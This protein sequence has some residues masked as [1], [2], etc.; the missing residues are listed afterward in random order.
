[1][2]LTADNKESTPHNI[3]PSPDV[4]AVIVCAGRGERT[5]L[6]YNKILYHIGRKTVIETTLDRFVSSGIKRCVLVVSERDEKTITELAHGYDGVSV[7]IG[8]ATRAKSVYN[9]LK[10]VKDCD[11]VVIHDGARPFVRPEIID[12]AVESAIKFGSGIAAVPTTDTIK[13]A[14]NGEVIRSLSRAN[15]YNAQTPQ[16]FRYNEIVS[17]YETA[18][19]VFT[20]DA[21]V[22]ASAGYTPRLVEGAYDNIKIT[23]ENDLVKSIPSGT[24][25]GIGFDVH[26]LVIGR[27]LILGGVDIPYDK[28]L[29]GHS[30]A[31]VLTHAIMDALL[32]AAGLPDIGVLFPD[33]AE[34]YT[35]I[36]SL[37]LLDRVASRIRELNKRIINISAVIMAQKPKLAAHIE[38]MRAGLS[39][40]LG[41][42]PADINISA[43]TTE[44][45]GIIGNGD[46]VAASASCLLTESYV[47]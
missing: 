18:D 26:R 31:D 15:L 17:A 23:T 4:A 34:E 2:K 36:S 44:M 11:I 27:P 35:N 16:A 37:I 47:G 24:K 33:D 5:G 28:G 14:E 32:S 30:D 42:S 8:G 9:G 46:A 38:N 29:D 45:L 39:A 13:Q 12:A 25:I 22:Y 43:T 10:A 21:E 40:R 6:S 1:M 19:G 3:A 20:D 7:C 41:I